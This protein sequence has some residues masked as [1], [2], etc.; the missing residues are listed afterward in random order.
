M[1]SLI[2][3]IRRFIYALRH[4]KPIY[5]YGGV[6]TFKI[7]TPSYNSI[8]KGKCILVTGGSSG[9]GRQTSILLSELGANLL[10][11][12]LPKIFDGTNFDI[13]QDNELATYAP[14]IKRSDEK[15]DFNRTR[16]EVYN[17]VRSLNPEPSAFIILDNEE[18]KI[19]EC[20]IGDD[21]KGEI[22]VISK[23]SND[24]FSLNCKDGQIDI[25]RIKP[26][27]KKEMS[28]RDY[29]NGTDKDKLLNKYVGDTNE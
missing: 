13:P 24:S 5:K 1:M 15:L 20:R 18:M 26:F 10:M 22:G 27:G 6:A 9:I 29:F 2:V 16:M 8:L 7:E 12:T 19:L 4:L 25:I 28:V 23:V 14:M 17:H 3:K 21:I 11:R